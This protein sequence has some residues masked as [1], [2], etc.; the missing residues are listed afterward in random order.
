MIEKISRN[1][2][3]RL[4]FLIMITGWSFSAAYGD[5]EIPETKTDQ[6]VELYIERGVD[7]YESKFNDHGE[8]G[9]SRLSFNYETL[10][11][12]KNFGN[13]F[14]DLGI[15]DNE[16]SATDTDEYSLPFSLHTEDRGKTS[17]IR[18]LKAGLR[19]S[20]SELTLVNRHHR[21]L[22]SANVTTGT[23]QAI[24]TRIDYDDTTLEWTWKKC[25]R[26]WASLSYGLF[27]EAGRDNHV[28]RL[29]KVTNFAAGPILGLSIIS[30]EMEAGSFTTAL[31]LNFSLAAGY[32]FQSHGSGDWAAVATGH[33]SGSLGL[34]LEF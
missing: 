5:T 24:K 29:K 7:I 34:R 18:S 8:K 13:W 19:N 23:I 17:L 28:T 16:S 15:T 14:L 25:L 30:P 3:L 20:A 27:I 12:R 11:A 6:Y 21:A 10:M 9:T 2:A 32:G 33:G 31:D 22:Y 4:L 1:L 26:S